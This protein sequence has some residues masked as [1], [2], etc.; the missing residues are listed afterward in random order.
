MLKATVPCH[1]PPT[2]DFL[3]HR[4]DQYAD[5]SGGNY[6][7]Q[8]FT[9]EDPYYGLVETRIHLYDDGTISDIGSRCLGS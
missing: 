1:L 4:L 8:Y 7:E 9:W 2:A 5:G 3:G 6:H